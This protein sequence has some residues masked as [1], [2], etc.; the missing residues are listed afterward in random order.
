MRRLAQRRR[1][2]DDLKQMK[3][4]GKS[5]DD[6]FAVIDLLLEFGT[7]PPPYRPHRLSGEWK[8][9]EE[10]H[11]DPDWLLIYA[12]TPDEIVLVR[13]GTHAELFG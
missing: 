9:A 7:L 3:R 8:G 4:R 10:C 6:L 12:V 2:R 5:L 13:T 1:F 11:I